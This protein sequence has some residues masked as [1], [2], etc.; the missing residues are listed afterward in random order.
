MVSI[1]GGK[2]TTH[3]RIALEALRRIDDA[4]L[5]G[6]PLQDNALIEATGGFGESDADVDPSIAS[7]LTRIYGAAAADVLAQR[8]LHSNAM[9]RI[10]PDGPDVWAQAYHAVDREWAVTVDDV[11][12]RRTTVAV[13]GLATAVLRSQIARLVGGGR[14]EMEPSAMPSRSRVD[15]AAV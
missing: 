12:R 7:H 8:G 14:S 13:R 4:R 9:E 1:A 2:L 15:F 6:L 11:L 3:R 10:H 5:A